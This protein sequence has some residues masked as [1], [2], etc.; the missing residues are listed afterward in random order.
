MPFKSGVGFEKL[1]KPQH[2]VDG[3][4]I[5]KGLYWEYLGERRQLCWQD[6]EQAHRRTVVW[7]KGPTEPDHALSGPATQ[8]TCHLASH[9]PVSPFPYPHLCASELQWRSNE[10]IRASTLW[11]ARCWADKVELSLVTTFKTSGVS[12]RASWQ[13]TTA[14][15][16]TV[17][18]RSNYM[19]RSG[20]YLQ[21]CQ[22]CQPLR[23]W[24]RLP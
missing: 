24:E 17:W 15:K 10:E 8:C 2:Y 11:I 6:H 20:C 16:K 22:N 3:W 4:P 5:F 18:N 21:P 23:Q 13:G 14:N 1:F 9:L 7:V 19:R 12:L